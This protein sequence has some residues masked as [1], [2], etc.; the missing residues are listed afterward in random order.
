MLDDLVVGLRC[1][2]YLLNGFCLRNQ[3]DKN[4]DAKKE[5]KNVCKQQKADHLCG[6]GC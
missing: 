5:K 6:A 2:S 3:L 1:D 4:E